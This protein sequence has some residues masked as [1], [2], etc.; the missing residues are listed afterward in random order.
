MEITQPITEVHPQQ[1]ETKTKNTISNT[2]SPPFFVMWCSPWP[3]IRVF[4]S[5]ICYRQKLHPEW[6]LPNFQLQD[7]HLKLE[8]DLSFFHELVIEIAQYCRWD[9]LLT[10]LIR[11]E[12][13]WL[14]SANLDTFQHFSRD[15]I[16]D[17][18]SNTPPFDFL[19]FYC[20]QRAESQKF[21]PSLSPYFYYSFF[22]YFSPKTVYFI[23]W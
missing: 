4:W 15:L 11:C 8:F 18:E 17:W 5:T 16:T 9:L 10:D 12:L 21:R 6:L 1:T 7:S 22:P 23:S 14:F 19:N 20:W 3:T 13:F 2:S